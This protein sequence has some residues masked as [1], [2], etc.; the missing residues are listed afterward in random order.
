MKTDNDLGN[1][2]GALCNDRQE[3]HYIR[4]TS[5]QIIS[6]LII[7]DF[8]SAYIIKILISLTRQSIEDISLPKTY[9]L[10]MH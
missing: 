9:I 4:R 10:Y 1:N 2:L 8:R 5:S 6:I 3:I 7:H